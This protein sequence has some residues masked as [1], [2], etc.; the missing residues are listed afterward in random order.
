M[1]SSPLICDGVVALVVIVLLPS[2]SWHRHPHRNGVVV[3]I[4]AIAL[5]ACRQAGIA[6]VNAQASLLSLRC[7]F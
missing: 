4:N 6:T 7:Q 2:S 3:I 1:V 5:A